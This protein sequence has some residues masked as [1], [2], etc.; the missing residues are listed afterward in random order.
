MVTKYFLHS[1]IVIGRKMEVTLTFNTATFDIDFL[2]AHAQI[3]D[4]VHKIFKHRVYKL[5]KQQ[6]FF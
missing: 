2:T 3:Q 5:H 1:S 4:I 6:Q